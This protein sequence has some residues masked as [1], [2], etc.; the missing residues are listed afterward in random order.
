MEYMGSN[1]LGLETKNAI[2]GQYRTAPK[3]EKISAPQRRFG[4]DVGILGEVG[5][6]DS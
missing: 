4:T 1:F 5:K 3:C 2:I 6:T